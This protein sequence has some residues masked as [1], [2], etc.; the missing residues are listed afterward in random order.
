LAAFDAD[1]QD[2]VAVLRL[3]P[4]RIKVVGQGHDAFETAREALVEVHRS[5][6]LVGLQGV[7]TLTREGKHAGFDGYLD[8]VRL[9]ARNKSI[10]FQRM[11]RG[12][13]VDGWKMSGA[14]APDAGI[15]IKQILN[16]SV[17]LGHFGEEIARKH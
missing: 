8:F 6:F 11:R 4:I 15:E 16:P 2:A 12:T 7:D 10:D 13:Q 14:N 9:K 3:Y 5:L 1:V 17:Q